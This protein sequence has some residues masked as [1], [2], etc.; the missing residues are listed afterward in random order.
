MMYH[1]YLLTLFVNNPEGIYKTI[2]QD[3]KR[4]T[5]PDDL[6]ELIMRELTAAGDSTKGS[7]VTIVPGLSSRNIRIQIVYDLYR[8]YKSGFK[9][10]GQTSLC[11]RISSKHLITYL[12]KCDIRMRSFK[13]VD[14]YNFFTA[15]MVGISILYCME[16]GK[17]PVAKALMPLNVRDSKKE[18]MIN[19]FVKAQHQMNDIRSYNNR[20]EIYDSYLLDFLPFDYQLNPHTGNPAH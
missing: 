17:L 1:E 18:Q 16:F 11:N 14:Q 3:H 4:M 12:S 19:T 8:L 6:Y 20:A 5:L 9:I 7:P 15:I 10:D 13:S 2:E